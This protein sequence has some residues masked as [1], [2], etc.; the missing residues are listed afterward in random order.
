MFIFAKKENMRIED[1][2]IKGKKVLVRVDFNVP[3]DGEGNI[4]DDTRMKKALPTIKYL[5][6]ND[7]AILL[8]SH[9]GRPQKDKLE[10][11]SINID[12]YSLRHLVK[13]LTELTGVQVLFAED[14]VG[15]QTE[16]LVEKLQPGQI[17]LLENTRFH[18]GEKSGDIELAQLMSRLADVY[19]NDA[20]GTAHREHSST[21]TVAKFFPTTHKALGL[22]MRS[23]IE[24]A[25]KV[26]SSPSRPLVAI[27]GGAKVSDKI[28]L[29]SRIIE[30]ANMVV[31]GGGMAYTFKKAQGGNI[32]DSLCEDDCIELA[33]ETLQRAEELGTEIILPTDSVV[34]SKFGEDGDIRTVDSSE[35]PSGYMGLDIGIEAIKEFAKVIMDAKTILWNGPMGVFEMDSFAQG[36][37]KIAEAVAQATKN[38][39]YSLVGGGDSVS[40]LNKTGLDKYISFISTGG[41]A[42]L[43]YLEGKKLPGI[44]AIDQKMDG[45]E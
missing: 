5:L 7:A 10:D 24:N 43:E 37:L 25:N 26:L 29:I 42:M 11:G 4:T 28:Q 12:K 35:I 16:N 2:D 15:G 27:L 30:V 6:E 31:I 22:L 39:G 38:G 23:E 36:T 21:A 13:H 8:M 18:K 9:L 34:S 3:M 33:L 20:F 32:G 14:C 41:G 19:I 17:L 40:A 44:A 45:E 1:I